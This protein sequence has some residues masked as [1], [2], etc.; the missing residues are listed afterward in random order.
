MFDAPGAYDRETGYVSC[1]APLAPAKPKRQ[2][3]SRAKPGRDELLAGA[4]VRS[5]EANAKLAKQREK[6]GGEAAR[7]GLVSSTTSDPRAPRLEITVDP[8]QMRAKRMRKSIITGARL[9][10]QEATQ[11]GFRGRWAML[12]LTYREGVGASPRHVSQL[13]HCIRMHL[14]RL[15]SAGRRAAL[16]YVWALELTTRLRP[17]YHILI[18]LPKGVTLPKP[19]KR[20][21]WAH[22]S[23]RIEWARNAVGYLA[24]YAS[25]FTAD[26][27]GAMPKGLRSHGVG[28]LNPESKREMRW[29]K[30][31]QEAR[32]LL[33]VLADI[34]KVLGGY[35]DKLTGQLWPSPWH[36]FFRPDGRL[37]A[38]KLA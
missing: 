36:V 16:R 7:A 23:T 4:R 11:G 33:G 12:T 30:A 24:K 38:W 35:A 18:R 28:G 13:L 21:W 19:D 32:E 2:R 3:I 25:K 10:G 1:V 22:G 34:R 5:T 8:L 27:A 6:A 29:W 14:R 37:I 31:P 26:V 9:H 15:G 17:H 20:G